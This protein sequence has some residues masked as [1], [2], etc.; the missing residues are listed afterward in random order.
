MPCP[1]GSCAVNPEFSMETRTAR[2]TV[3]TMKS[4]SAP[5]P[6][7]AARPLAELADLVGELFDADR[8]HQVAVEAGLQESLLVLPHRQGGQRDDRDRGRA[9][10]ALEVS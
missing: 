9:R 4:S 6:T 5:G 8:L 2:N 7:P 1:Y 3:S 10:L